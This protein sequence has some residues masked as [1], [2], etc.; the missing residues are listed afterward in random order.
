[1][2]ETQTAAGTP[3]APIFR[4]VLGLEVFFGLASLATIGLFPE[5]TATRFAWEIRSLAMAAVLGGLYFA[6]APTLVLQFLARR[7]EMIRVIIPAAIAF[8]TAELLATFLHW[9]L[10]FI[11]TLRF[12]IWFASYILPPPL[13]AIMYLYQQ[14][15]ST[16][17]P[18]SRPLPRPLRSLFLVLG[19]LLALDAVVGFVSPAYLTSSFPF[20]LTPLTARVL[21]GWVLVLGT[22]LLSIAR[23]NDR[24]RV[25]IASPVLILLLP[26]VAVQLVRFGDQVDFGHPRLWANFAVFAVLAVAGIYL[27]RGDWRTTM[28]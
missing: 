16:E 1:M 22:L 26:A 11:G 12:N 4:A 5:E 8:T 13:L 6:F 27:A 9:D 28:R 19:G 25:R 7:W 10:F 17:Q 15:L 23:E 21:S 2:P 18:V 24:D 3:I 20:P 14:R